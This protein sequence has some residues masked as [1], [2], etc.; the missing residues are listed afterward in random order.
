MAD[1]SPVPVP[2]TVD[3]LYIEGLLMKE[4]FERCFTVGG[5]LP[6]KDKLHK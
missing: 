4:L 3:Y 2:V 1:T 6:D 5:Y